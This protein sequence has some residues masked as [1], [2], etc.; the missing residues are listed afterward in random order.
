M[1]LPTIARNL[2]RAGYRLRVY[3]R[4]ASKAQPLLELDGVSLVQTP[5]EVAEPGGI[6][7]S[8]LA[9]DHGRILRALDDDDAAC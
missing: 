7:L 9:D 4:T 1:G 6:V 3:N 5:A 2:A 8:M